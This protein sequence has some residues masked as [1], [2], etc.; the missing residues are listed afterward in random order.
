[1]SQIQ[2]FLLKIP[3]LNRERAVWVY[4]PTNYNAN[5]KPLPVIYMQDGQNIFYD[6]L[7]A[8]GTAW[9]VDKTMDAIFEHF[10]WSAVIVGVESSK[11][12]RLSE[13]SPWLC[14]IPLEDF[15]NDRGGEGE[16]Y[17]EFFANDL[18]NYIQSHYNVDGSRQAT[19][20]IGSS[21]GGLISLYLGLKYQHLYQTMGLFST[22]TP[23]NYK[24]YREF[25]RKTPQTLP[26]NAMIFCGG[27]EDI[28]VSAKEME[29]ASV[30]L[31]QKLSHRKV[32]TQLV[33]DSNCY[34]TESAW[35]NYFGAFAVDFLQRYNQQSKD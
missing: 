27:K 15:P 13:Y 32:H 24:C 29:K 17:A 12:R 14:S 10:G 16:Q 1:M 22:F 9:H 7:T 21:M 26:Q 31:Y 34:H 23:F 30:E 20:V 3:Q 8:Y 28:S 35:D 33:L 19:A 2:S 25:L 11:T 4:L 6:N 18:K 5:C